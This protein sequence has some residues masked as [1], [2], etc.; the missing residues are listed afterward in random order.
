MKLINLFDTFLK[1]IVNLNATRVQELETSTDAIKTAISDSNWKPHI[2]GW[3]AQGSWAHKTIIRPVD[4]GEFDADLIVFVEKV[5]G[6]NAATYIDELYTILRNHGTYSDKVR[7]WSHCV[8]VT[9]ANERKVDIAPCIVNR[10]GFQ[11]L[12]VCN[13]DSDAFERT[14]PRQYTDWLIEQNSYSGSNSFRKVTR[15]IKYLRDIKTTFTCSSVLLTTLL[16]TL[17]NARDRDGQDFIDTPTALKTMFGRLDD[18]LQVNTAK[19]VVSNPFLS[20][21]DFAASMTSDQYANFRNMVHKYR[22]WID[23]ALAETDRSESISKWRR[24]FSEDFAAD[25]VLEEAKSASK[26]AVVLLKDS[27]T[28]ASSFSGDLVDAIKAFGMTAITPSFDHQPHMQSPRWR[29][30][31]TGHIAVR[32]VATLYRSKG[33]GAIRAVNSL[34]PLP[35]GYWIEF[36]AVSQNAG[37]QMSNDYRVHWRI[38]NTDE[39]AYSARQLRGGFYDSNHANAH[40]EELKYR[41]V[42]L[43]EA[44]VVRKRD[45]VLVGKSPTFRVVVE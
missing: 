16:G 1:D 19:P 7:R 43:A 37:I 39:Q 12:E 44:F 17:I 41:G 32:I 30:A 36:R 34:D 3:M 10:N 5:Q 2:S 15:L 23:D 6:W 13:R 45:E 27:V 18:W 22:G 29:I 20:T 14:E 28:S 40:F 24:V 4:S 31:P 25:V 38:T 26:S 42:H 11:E 35:K 8:T 21:E 9:Y 33:Y